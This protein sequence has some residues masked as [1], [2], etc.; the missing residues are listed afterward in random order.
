[1]GEKV[2]FMSMLLIF[3]LFFIPFLFTTFTN[4]VDSSNV[5]T[6]STEMQQLIKSEGGI[7]LK[8]SEAGKRLKEKGINTIYRINEEREVSIELI[9]AF[10][11]AGANLP[12][13]EVGET[14]KVTY[15]KNGF[16][17]SNTVRILK[18]R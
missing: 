8:V 7:T 4:Q 17:T 3:A 13:Q 2:G 16:K 15:E 10:A 1:M 5:L 14:I 9:N 6:A 18:R 12:G 11:E